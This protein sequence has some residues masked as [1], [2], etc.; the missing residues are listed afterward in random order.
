MRLVQIYRALHWGDDPGWAPVRLRAASATEVVELGELRSLVYRTV[1]GRCSADW[2][3]IF[4][5]ERPL[6]C[7]EPGTGL[8][9]IAG[10]DYRVEKRGI[11][12]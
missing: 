3:H 10:G 11:V 7:V 8:L 4:R 12:G 1:K 5:A 9:V 2:E 6:L